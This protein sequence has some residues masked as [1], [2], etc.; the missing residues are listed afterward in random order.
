[1]EKEKEIE[2]KPYVY[3]TPE[4]SLVQEPVASYGALDLDVYKRYTYADYLTWMDDKRRELI[5]GFFHL[6]SAPKRRHAFTSLNLGMLIGDFIKKNKGKCRIYLAPFDVRLPLYES[7]DNDKVYDVF[8]PDISVI[9][10]LSK[11]DENG[12]IGAPDLVVEITS[13]ST[14]VYDWNRKF[15]RYEKAGVREYWIVDPQAKTTNVFILQPDGAYDE[16][17]E[18]DSN[19]KAPVF[20]FEGLEIDLSEIFED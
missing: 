14:K 16:G 9:C 11:L 13:P 3:A 19:Q 18:Y 20:I 15:V 12:C 17:T 5:D 8:Q 10:D 1:M 4:P 6:M 2:K 7:I